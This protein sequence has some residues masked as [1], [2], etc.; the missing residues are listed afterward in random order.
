[1]IRK[2]IIRNILY[3]PLSTLLSIILLST[4]T[5][6]VLAILTLQQQT[7][8]KFLNDLQDI[9]VVVGAK[10]SPLQLVLSAVY[11]IDAPTGNIAVRELQMLTQNPLIE[12]VTPL[13][14]GDNFKGYRIIGTDSTYLLRYKAT[15]KKGKMFND[16]FEVT[17]GENVAN[18]LQLDIGK[19]FYSTHGIAEEGDEH[20]NHAYTVVGILKNTNTVVDNLIIGNI[21][22]VHH[23]H[24]QHSNTENGEEHHEDEITAALIK[25]RSPMAMM[26]FPRQVNAN[27]NLMAAVPSIEI[28][29]LTSLLSIGFTTLQYVALAIIVMAG[30]S[31]FISLYTKLQQRIHE[32]ALLRCYGYSRLT[33]LQLVFGE[34]LLLGIMGF[35]MGYIIS[36]IGLNFLHLYSMQTLN[37]PF[38]YNYWSVYHSYIFAG[39]LAICTIA[40]TLPAIRAYYLKI[41]YTLSHA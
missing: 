39:I 8:Q 32:M 28:N 6:I 3:K 4:G 36:I 13:A 2:L 17:I 16:N 37:I 10:G 5:A 22:T 23:I 7:E 27:S 35:V 14:Y 41:A 31:I 19:T 11:Q 33:L 38:L 12:M 40:A 9:D 20:A 26:T 18:K 15:C 29:R 24:E 30:I 25:F 34:S 1:M 21:E